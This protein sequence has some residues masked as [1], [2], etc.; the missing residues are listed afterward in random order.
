MWSAD[1]SNVMLTVLLSFQVLYLELQQYDKWKSDT[2]DRVV[3]EHHHW[4]GALHSAKKEHSLLLS[5]CHDNHEHVLKEKD[6][7]MTQLMAS[8]DA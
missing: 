5:T 8:K 2:H 7:K 4:T 1:T 6:T 3:A